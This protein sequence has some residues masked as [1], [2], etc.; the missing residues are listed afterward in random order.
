MVIAYKPS[1][2]LNHPTAATIN[3]IMNHT[4]SLRPL[5]DAAELMRSDSWRRA[6]IAV[7]PARTK[8]IVRSPTNAV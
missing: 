6:P 2:A 7:S 1:K 8:K 4:K 5:E 3:I